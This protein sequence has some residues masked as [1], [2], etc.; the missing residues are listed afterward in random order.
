MNV[1][2]KMYIKIKYTNEYLST[3]KKKVQGKITL[4]KIENAN[5]NTLLQ[6]YKI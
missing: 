5:P 2:E 6:L 3:I 4:S 1:S